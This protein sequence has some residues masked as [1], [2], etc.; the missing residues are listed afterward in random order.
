MDKRY[1]FLFVI[2]EYSHGGTNKS[3][4]NLLGLI[5]KSKYDISIYCLYEDGGD[6]YKQVFAPYVL[7]KSK[8]YYWMHDNVCTRKVIGLYNKKTKRNHFGWLYSR[9]V[10]YIQKKNVFDVVVAYQ[11]G[12]ATMFVSEFQN[13]RKIAWIHCDYGAWAKNNRKKKDEAYYR[14]VNSIVCVSESAK[15]SF[16]AIFPEFQDKTSSIYNLVNVQDVKMLANVND[17]HNDN[18]FTIVSVGRLSSVKQFEG[19]PEIANYIKKNAKRPIHWLIIGS[20][21]SEGAIREEIAKFSLQNEVILLGAK[22]NPY[23]YISNT[24]LVVCTSVSESFSYIIAEAKVLHT[25]VLSNDFPVAY[26]VV[27][28]QTGWIAN[29]KDMPQL[30]TRIINDEDGEYSRKK[31]SAMNYEYSN[32]EILQKI[33]SLFQS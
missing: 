31:T 14:N 24:D 12:T 28:E 7:K 23:P 22:D 19:I 9:E 32:E 2:P 26:E 5:D 6:Y 16:L 3:L 25:P 20:G 17:N 29:I 21:A 27:D 8:L 18:V 11:E 30:L 33:D 4:E 10:R 13:V 15:Q 1:R